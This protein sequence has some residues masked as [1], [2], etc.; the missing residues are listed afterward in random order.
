MNTILNKVKPILEVLKEHLF[1]TVIS[2]FCIFSLAV[3]LIATLVMHE[4]IVPVC[5]LVMIEAA[6]AMFMKK[7]E[8]WLHGIVVILQIVV[9]FIIGRAPLM[10]LSVLIY[11]AATVALI[12]LNH[13]EKETVTAEKVKNNI[14]KAEFKSKT[15]SKK[16]A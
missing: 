10:I 12:L 8:L 3:I 1:L 9:G 5:L 14:P 7:S 6:M 13:Q 11:V 2:V 4:F 15:K 16:K